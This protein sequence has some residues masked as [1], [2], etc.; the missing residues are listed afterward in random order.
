MRR[1]GRV[2]GVLVLSLLIW[3]VETSGARREDGKPL[4]LRAHVIVMFL[5][6]P[7]GS[8]TAVICNGWDL[9]REFQAILQA[10]LNLIAA[11]LRIRDLR[12][13]AW[14]CSINGGVVSWTAR[15]VGKDPW[16]LQSEVLRLLRELPYLKAGPD[17]AADPDGGPGLRPSSL[18]GVSVAPTT[19]SGPTRTGWGTIKVIY[20]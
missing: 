15:G 11:R 12:L 13:G 4:R 18:E 8:T 9:N 5:G 17:G 7:V 2:L 19:T 1:R 16:R 10:D 6:I 14:W 3:T 20:R